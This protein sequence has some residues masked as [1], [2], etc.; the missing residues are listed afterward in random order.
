MGLE[1]TDLITPSAKKVIDDALNFFQS[2]DIVSVEV[3]TDAQFMGAA[4]L[5]K[6]IDAE[7]DKIE[8]AF[9]SLKDPITKQGKAIDAE[10]NAVRAVKQSKRIFINQAMVNYDYQKKIEARKA[11][12]EAE[13]AARRE[14]QRLVDEANRKAEAAAKSS[15]AGRNVVAER[16]AAA[17]EEL[18]QQAAEVVAAPVVQTVAPKVEGVSIKRVWRG[19]V[20]DKKAAMKYAVERGFFNFFDPNEGAINAQAKACNG[21]VPIDG[22]EWFQEIDTKTRRSSW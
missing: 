13:Q 19:R 17:A 3:K 14:Q 12:E 8:T 21:E 15:A 16:Q 20:V 6:R 10:F 18:K 5:L 22:I 1:H 9:H 4:E 7:G 2:D 11:Q